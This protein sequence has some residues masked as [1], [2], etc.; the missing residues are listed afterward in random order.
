MRGRI[1]PAGSPGWRIRPPVVASGNLQMEAF[2]KMRVVLAACAAVFTGAGV[3]AASTGTS[4]DV[5]ATVTSS[6][7]VSASTLAFGDYDPLSALPTTGT[8]IVNVTCSFL[9]PFNVGLNAGLHSAS[10]TTR[11]MQSVDET[12]LA[13]ELF[14]DATM[15]LNW[16]T[17]VGTDTLAAAGLGITAVPLPVYG[18]IPAQQHVEAGSYSDTIQVTVTF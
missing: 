10:V 12:E 3:S 14:R 6:C 18:R 4:F 15:L 17:T 9:T 16:G 7:S 1:R 11:K 5:T 13:Y 8:T 2:M